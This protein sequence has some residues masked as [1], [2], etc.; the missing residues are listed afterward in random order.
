M[1]STTKKYTY[2]NWLDGDIILIYSP[3]QY[4][5]EDIPIIV[6]WDSFSEADI[7]KIKEK[8]K[9]VFEKKVSHLLNNR[10]KAFIENYDKSKIRHLHLQEEIQ[11]CLDIIS[12]DTPNTQFIILDKWNIS[13]TLQDFREVQEYINTTIKKGINPS[14][15]IIHSPNSKYKS[16]KKF[17]S[18]IFAQFTWEYYE[19]LFAFDNKTKS[20]ISTHQKETSVPRKINP[21]PAIFINEDAYQLFKALTKLTVKTKEERAGYAFIF[22]SMV[23]KNLITRGMKHQTFITFL[24]ENFKT[25]I[26]ASSFPYKHTTSKQKIF[27]HLYEEYLESIRNTL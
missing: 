11:Q 26:D 6:D 21:H 24:N 3:S 5:Q 25:E 16:K 2:I 12:A 8:Q 20:K 27:N 17:Q 22:H 23:N 1:K 15:D 4:N 10:K 19:F 9:E 14:Y 7:I 18:Q 13:I